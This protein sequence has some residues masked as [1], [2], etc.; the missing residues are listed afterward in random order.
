MPDL[1]KILLIASCMFMQACSTGQ[2]K[3]S[4]ELLSLPE[5]QMKIRQ[6]QTRTFDMKNQNQVLRGVIAALQDMGYIIERINNTMGFVTAGKLDSKGSGVIELTVIVQ[7]AANQHT[8]IRVNALHNTKAIEDPE[9]YQRFF[10]IVERSLFMT[11]QGKGECCTS[12]LSENDLP[13]SH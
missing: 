7:A 12:N 13:E 1:Y 4:N 10:T 5:N 9:V 6:A 8:E 2:K 3:L 11:K